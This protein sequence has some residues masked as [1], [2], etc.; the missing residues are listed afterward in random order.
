MTEPHPSDLLRRN[1]AEQINI[2]DMLAVIDDEDS[3]VDQLMPVIENHVAAIRARYEAVAQAQSASCEQW[4]KEA[5]G[6]QEP[7]RSYA[8]GRLHAADQAFLAIRQAADR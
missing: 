5:H 4:S 2:W 1:L 7:D 6:A 3:L 8:I